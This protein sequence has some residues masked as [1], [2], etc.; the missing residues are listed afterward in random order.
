MLLVI[1]APDV[2]P[3]WNDKE[4]KEEI[5][6]GRIWDLFD[7]DWNPGGRTASVT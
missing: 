1:S 4:L 3:Y 5:K 2:Q 6:D 7:V